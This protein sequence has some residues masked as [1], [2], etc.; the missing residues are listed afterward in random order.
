MDFWNKKNSK[1]I[2][3]RIPIDLAYRSRLSSVA[4]RQRRLRIPRP[5]IFS[6]PSQILTRLWFKVL[7]IKIVCIIATA[8]PA[9][10]VPAAFVNLLLNIE[11]MVKIYG[12]S[13]LT[14][15]EDQDRF[16]AFN[17]KSNALRLFCWCSKEEK[18]NSWQQS[19]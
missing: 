17:K 12:N 2:P 6:S 16:Y 8:K 19:Y 13:L 1:T 18:N 10:L 7:C 5:V 9:Y 15:A 3:S 14:N 4:S 11:K